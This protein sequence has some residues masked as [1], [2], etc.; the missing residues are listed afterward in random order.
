MFFNSVQNFDSWKDYFGD[1]HGSM[2]GLLGALYQIG[3]LCSI[4][5]VPIIADR[6]GR[7]PPIAIGCVIMIAGAA[8]QGACQ[9]LGSK[10]LH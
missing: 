5:I 1:P 2:L 10:Q 9:N 8:M 6:W 3:S 4:P 7:K